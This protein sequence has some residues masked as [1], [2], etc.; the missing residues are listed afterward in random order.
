MLMSVKLPVLCDLFHN[1][2]PDHVSK[3]SSTVCFNLLY[4]SGIGK[5]TAD[6]W[7]TCHKRRVCFS[8]SCGTSWRWKC[9]PFGEINRKAVYSFIGTKLYDVTY[10]CSFCIK[11]QTNSLL[12]FFWEKSTPPPTNKQ[13]NKK[14]IPLISHTYIPPYI[15]SGIPLPGVITWQ[16]NVSFPSNIIISR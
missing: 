3:S 4:Y 5:S 12:N 14:T 7:S 2:C 9:N 13:T 1:Q 8:R 6:F 15:L 10:S 11:I 16:N